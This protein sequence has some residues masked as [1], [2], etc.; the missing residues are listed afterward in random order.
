[1]R[2]KHRAAPLTGPSPRLRGEGGVRRQKTLGLWRGPLTRPHPSLRASGERLAASANHGAVRSHLTV[3][4][5][6]SR[7]VDRPLRHDEVD[8]PVDE[9]LR[10]FARRIDNRLLMHIEA[11]I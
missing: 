11:G 10:A 9:C 1:M 4:L 7:F 2:Q 8:A 3:A 5:R 6:P